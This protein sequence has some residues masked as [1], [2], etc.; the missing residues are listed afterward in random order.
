[1][2]PPI[3]TLTTDFGTSGPYVAAMK[4]VILT[5]NPQVRIVD[6]SHQIAPQN[7]EEGALCLASVHRFFPAGTIHV[8]VVDPGVG[9]A[10]RLLCVLMHDQLFLAP[11]NGLLTW[12]ARGATKIDRVELSEP[13]FWRSSVSATFHGRDM[14][15][16]TA[17]HLSLGVSPNQ[18]GRRVTGWVELRWPAPVRTGTQL[19]GEVLAVDHFGNLIT[20]LAESDLQLPPG[21]VPRVSCCGVDIGRLSRTYSDVAE[22]EL[23]AVIGSSELLEIAVRQGNAAERLRARRGS[24]VMLQFAPQSRD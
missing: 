12:S 22:G 19:I 13:R 1:M 23:V 21:V 20:N 17:A 14:L 3:I 8:A 10:R 18:L 6:V 9:S 2:Q 11:D 15:A 5:L 4:G 7:I 16:P 24:P